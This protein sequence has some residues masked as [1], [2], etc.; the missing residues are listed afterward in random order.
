[1]RPEI[2]AQQVAKEAHPVPKSNPYDFIN[3]E[4]GKNPDILHAQNMFR[5]G[6]SVPLAR[7]NYLGAMQEAAPIYSTPG[8]LD[9][10]VR[11]SERMKQSIYGGLSDEII[12][13]HE[14]LQL[15]KEFQA[16]D[17]R[18]RL[19]PSNVMVRIIFI[20]AFKDSENHKYQKY[21][22]QRK[23]FGFFMNKNSNLLD[24][25]ERIKKEFGWET[26]QT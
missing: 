14:I 9:D 2:V 17:D 3:E 22:L 6:Q 19:N 20:H 1:M 4:S 26:E 7:E 8:Y 10:T 21:Q 5:P 13:T 25:K 24:V 12:E 23:L 18:E 15:R 11:T 16:L